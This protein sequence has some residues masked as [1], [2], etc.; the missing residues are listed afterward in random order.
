MLEQLLILTKIKAQLK[1][2]ILD[3]SLVF[4]HAALTLNHCRSARSPWGWRVSPSPSWSWTPQTHVSW[5]APKC[6][7]LPGRLWRS[8]AET[9]NC[10]GGNGA[11]VGLTVKASDA[12]V[13]MLSPHDDRHD[14]VELQLPVWPRQSLCTGAQHVV[15]QRRVQDKHKL[16]APVSHQLELPDHSG[17]SEVGCKP[18]RR[19]NRRFV[20]S[21]QEG[22]DLELPF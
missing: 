8:P 15:G 9:W 20:E 16:G 11:F 10:R 1:L 19:Q 22:G 17:G 2:Q 14:D 18:E 13:A 3:S 7:E 12:A 21:S 4:F 6:S 5:R